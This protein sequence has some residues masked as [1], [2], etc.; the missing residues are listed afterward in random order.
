MH[1]L[2]TVQVPLSF[3]FK[4]RQR[5]HWLSKCVFFVDYVVLDSFGDIFLLEVHVPSIHNV[6]VFPQ[7]AFTINQWFDELFE[8]LISQVEDSEQK[9]NQ[10]RFLVLLFL[11]SESFLILVF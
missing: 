11:E 2:L 7:Q 5:K 6:Q 4:G 1:T 3:S 8:D 10:A 9:I